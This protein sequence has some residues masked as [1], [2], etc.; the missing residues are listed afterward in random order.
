MPIAKFPR[1]DIN[2]DAILGVSPQDEED[3]VR[4]HHCNPVLM[5]RHAH[6]L[7]KILATAVSH[8]MAARCTC[9]CARARACA[10]VCVC[11]RAQIKAVPPSAPLAALTM[12]DPSNSSAAGTLRGPPQNLSP[13]DATLT[14]YVEKW[15]LKDASKYCEPRVTVAVYDANGKLVEAVQVWVHVRHTMH[16]WS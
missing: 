3:Q 9:L 6:R 8:I 11:A 13:G 14:I 10:C 1:S 16:V 15:G 2:A 5:R 12:S 7:A 4:G